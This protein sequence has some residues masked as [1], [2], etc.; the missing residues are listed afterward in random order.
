VADDGVEPDVELLRGVLAPAVERDRDAPVDVTG[1]R[2]GADLLEDVLAEPDD[3]GP[4]R[5][6]RLAL[7]EPAPELLGE[8]GQVEEEVLGLDE[9]RGLTVDAGARVDKVVGVELVAAR[10]ALV[11][12]G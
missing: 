10:V 5:A 6:R 4:P 3:V 8:G 1:H 11:P 12:A 2:P 9:L 7:V